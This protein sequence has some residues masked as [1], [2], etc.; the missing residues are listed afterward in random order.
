MDDR[1]S[2]RENFL[3]QDGGG[4][5]SFLPRRWRRFGGKGKDSSSS[6]LAMLVSVPGPSSTDPD[7][8]AVGGFAIPCA[9]APARHGIARNHRARTRFSPLIRYGRIFSTGKSISWS[10]LPL[11][12]YL[13]PRADH[14]V[15]YGNMIRT[16]KH[17]NSPPR[18]MNRGY[19]KMRALTCTQVVSSTVPSL[20]RIKL[21]R[22]KRR[23]RRKECY[24][25][26]WL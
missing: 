22:M 23:L 25:R 14:K 21:S 13:P 10:G 20:D 15:R 1:L 6:R 7:P 11:R 3:H 9:A 18:I 4:S 17:C 16:A 12:M 24:V 19:A 8:V 5:L 26:F 2:Y